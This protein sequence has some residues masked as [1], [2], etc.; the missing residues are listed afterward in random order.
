MSVASPVKLLAQHMYS[1]YI[2]TVVTSTFT[3]RCGDCWR[4]SPD[5]ISIQR[6]GETFSSEEIE[7]GMGSD[8]RLHDSI[9]LTMILSS[10]NDRT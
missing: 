4:G 2:G 6:R 3:Y 7:A 1:W 9:N 5:F 10:F 8:S